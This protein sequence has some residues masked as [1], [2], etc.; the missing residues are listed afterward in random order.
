MKRGAPSLEWR[1][2]AWRWTCGRSGANEDV[3]LHRLHAL[4]VAGERGGLVAFV[5]ALREA[6]QLHRAVERFDLDRRRSH[7]LVL[8]ELG[9]HLRGDGRVVDVGAGGG[10]VAGHG[11]AGGGEQ[12]DGGG[13]GGEGVAD[14]HG[15]SPFALRR[16]S[17][18]EG[19]EGWLFFRDTGPHPEAGGN[20][21]SGA[22]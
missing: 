10:L 15:G 9:L 4:D 14:H 3:V 20:G 2:S 7:G 12:R 1:A 21:E 6:G 16:P 13:G 17:G 11:A 22:C 19:R 18:K 8:D 5:F